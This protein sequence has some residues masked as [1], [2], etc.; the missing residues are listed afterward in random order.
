MMRIV[1][2][3]SAMTNYALFGDALMKQSCGGLLPL[4]VALICLSACQLGPTPAPRG[5]SPSPTAAATA[6]A[7]RCARLAQRGFTPCP[8]TA[9]HLTLPPTT[10]RNATNGAISDTT[11]QQWGKA[12]QL[13]EAYYRWALQANA[14]SAL[15][16]GGLADASPQAV[17]NLFGTDLMDL[18][19]AK[20]AGGSLTYQ[21]P[22][23]PVPQVVS[24]P[25]TLQD[26]MRRQGLASSPYGLAVRFTG[27][28]RRGIRT[29]DGNERVIVTRD[30]A[31]QADGLVWGELR[32]DPDLG[33]IWYEHGSY[34]C[35]DSVRNVCGL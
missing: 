15:T 3:L 34:G 19:D 7:A 9:D 24:L 6:D 16:G 25:A 21:P 22:S 23:F 12:F 30:A 17:S 11:A 2:I 8:P 32:S 29:P 10:I 31:F 28:T 18:D 5:A 27:P 4:V 35:Q 26:S 33:E 13:T 14:R 1:R 20:R